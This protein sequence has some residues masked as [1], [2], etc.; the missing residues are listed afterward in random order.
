MLRNRV[1]KLDNA[2]AA[3]N[4]SV[5]YASSVSISIAIQ[6]IAPERRSKG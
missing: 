6:K 3:E 2:H 1:S 5:S 4:T